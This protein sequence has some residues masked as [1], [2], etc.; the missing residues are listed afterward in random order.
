MSHCRQAAA[1]R[2]TRLADVRILALI[3]TRGGAGRSFLAASLADVWRRRGQPVL[4][5]D[6]DAH[7]GLALELGAAQRPLAGLVANCVEGRAWPDSAQT[8]SDGVS[9]LPCGEIAA[10]SYREFEAGL[11][12]NPQ[13]LRQQLDRL[14]LPP[15]TL[16]LVDT[17]RLPSVTAEHAAHLADQVLGVLTPDASSYAQLDRLERLCPARTRYVINQF[18]PTRPLQRDLRALLRD[19]LGARLAPF[20]LHRDASVADAQARN[21]ALLDEA[22]HCQAAEDL[23]LLASWL[24]AGLDPSAA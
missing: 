3:A 6:L 12:A 4:L 18:E 24:S 22:P 2:T 7:N 20:T 17:P 19:E 14:E 10:V 15:H 5:V 13:W 9:F 8:N 11:L 16:V 1:Q 23:Q 21:L